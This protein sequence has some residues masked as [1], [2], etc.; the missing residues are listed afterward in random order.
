M[1]EERE[2]KSVTTPGGHAVVLKTFLTGRE[3][4][5]LQTP[6]LKSADEFPKDQIADVG[7]RASIFAA[8]QNLT[9]NTIIVSFDG[10]KDGEVIEG[11]EAKFNLVET[12]LDLPASEFKFIVA[13]ANAVVANPDADEQKKT[14]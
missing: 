9:L 5:A 2:T 6:Y 10:K 11:T 14:S 7:L 3:A 8:T 13:T 12:L 1:A 4:R